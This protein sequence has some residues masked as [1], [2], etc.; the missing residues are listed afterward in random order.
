MSV[1]RGEAWKKYL[2]H[3]QYLLQ[4]PLDDEYPYK[5]RARGGIYRIYTAIVYPVYEEKTR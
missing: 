3:Y 1:A 2:D 5:E 4:Y